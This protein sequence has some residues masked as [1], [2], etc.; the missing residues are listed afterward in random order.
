[1]KKTP[2]P[3]LAAAI[4]ERQPPSSSLEKIRTAAEL[5]REVELEIEDLEQRLKDLKSR[6][7]Q[8]VRQELPEMMESVGLRELKLAGEGNLPALR[9]KLYTEYKASIPE[10]WP[11]DRKRAAFDYLDSF[12][13]GDLITTDVVINFPRHKRQAALV[14]KEQLSQAYDVEV[15]E[16]VHWRTLTAWLKEVVETGDD[17]VSLDLIGGF[18]AKTVKIDKEED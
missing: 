18:V 1:M 10:S 12:G 6:R 14:L 5:A 15:S 3:D 8:L 7:N 17:V 16:S 11:S 9:L 13:A 2:S 4:M